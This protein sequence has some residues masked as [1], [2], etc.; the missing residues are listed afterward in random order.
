MSH[1]L[2]YL[3][4]SLGQCLKAQRCL[5]TFSLSNR[6]LS[7]VGLLRPGFW[8]SARVPVSLGLDR[9]AAHRLTSF[10]LLLVGFG[11]SSSFLGISWALLD[12][13]RSLR[14]CLPSKPRL[15]WC[16]SAVYFLWNLLLLGPRI[17]AIATFSVVFPYC[18]ALH[19]LSLWLVLLYW[20]WLQDTKFM[21]NSNGEWLYRVTVALI[22]YFSWFN[23]SGG[24]TRGR[25]TIHLCF[26]LSDSVL[27]VTTS[28]V[29]DSTWLPGGV[30]LW[31]ALGGA[32]FSLGLVLRMIYY[33]R[34]HPSCSWEPDFVDGTLRLLPPERPPKLIYNR[35]ATRLAQ[36]FFAKLKTQA[37]LPQAV[38]LNG[39][40]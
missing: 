21:P 32:C 28:W 35:R 36:N 3:G 20:V 27:L 4:M 9:Q 37:A 34:L 22:L 26:I 19:F 40:L 24:R 39:V 10:L 30:L 23:V 6:I 38:Q 7:K 25:A 33:L 12:Y 16:S 29:T 14:T 8:V 13:H 2:S 18:L 5:Q 15:G 31:A 17:C 11:I 1:T